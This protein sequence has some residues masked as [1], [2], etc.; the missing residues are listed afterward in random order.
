VADSNPVAH[1]IE[2]PS[3]DTGE[4]SIDLDRVRMGPSVDGKCV[5][6]GLASKQM[7]RIGPDDH[8]RLSGGTVLVRGTTAAE[9]KSGCSAP[10]SWFSSRP[11][12]SWQVARALAAT[13]RRQ[14]AQPVRWVGCCMQPALS[15]YGVRIICRRCWGGLR[16]E[17]GPSRRGAHS[18][19]GATAGGGQAAPALDFGAQEL[20]GSGSPMKLAWGLCRRGS[21]AVCV[22]WFEAEDLEDD[23]WGGVDGAGKCPDLA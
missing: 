8:P 11:R 21:V 20:G 15:R 13:R 18:R 23:A 17:S 10:H 12:V 4:S 22:V 5:A 16:P 7:T 1:L 6:G 14:R 2:T 19:Q 9:S 3:G